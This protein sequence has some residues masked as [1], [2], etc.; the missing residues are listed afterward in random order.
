MV[1]RRMPVTSHR[2]R[3]GLA[4]RALVAAGFV[5]AGAGLFLVGSSLRVGGRPAVSANVPVDPSAADQSDFTANNSPSV[6]KNPRD[7]RVIAVANRIDQQQFGCALHVSHDGGRSWVAVVIPFPAGEEAPPRCFAPD[8]TFGPRGTMY[9]VFVT[10]HG[11]GNVPHAAW[12]VTSGDSGRTLSTP[13]R[14]LGPLAFQVEVVA[15]PSRPG[16]L[17]LGWLQGAATGLFSFTA[18]GNPILV[19]RSDDGGMTWNAPV[20]VAP[21]ARQRIVAPSMAVS[22]DGS[23]FLSYL[24]LGRDA[25]DYRGLDVG[26]G[27]PPFDGTWQLIVARSRDGGATWRETVADPTVVPIERFVVFLPPTPAL[28]VDVDNVYVAFQDGRLGDPDVWLWASHD[29]G[30]TFASAVRVNDTVRRDGTWQYLPALAVADN[31]RVDVMYYDRRDDRQDLLNEVSLQSSFDHGR[32]FGHR[33]VL[34]DHAFDSRVSPSAFR[35]MF[36]LGSRV[37]LLAL[38]SGSIGVWTD[39]RAARPETGKQDVATVRVTLPQTNEWRNPLRWG[40][41]A[42]GLVAGTVLVAGLVVGRHNPS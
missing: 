35:Q 36:D 27:G 18:D 22:R 21:P 24:D 1:V 5:V 40:G 17:Y 15:D 38:P 29:G 34:S 41:V 2:L 7:G 3:T 33:I 4:A 8:V 31:G 42:L 23:L 28:A 25:L 37:G 16:R 30:R 11:G 26:Q 20:E 6:A 32:T 10:L 9:L 13:R 19:S 39:T 12:L 14:L